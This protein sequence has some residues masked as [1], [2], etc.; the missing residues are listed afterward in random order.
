MNSN[1]ANKLAA[2]VAH[3]SLAAGLTVA[4]SGAASVPAQSAT[5]TAKSLSLK[6]QAATRWYKSMTLKVN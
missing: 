4:L 6:P 3:F 1:F 2:Q 5:T